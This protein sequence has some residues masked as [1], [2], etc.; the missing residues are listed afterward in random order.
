MKTYQG[1]VLY[2]HEF[3]T[4]IV[5]GDEWSALHVYHYQLKRRMGGTQNWSGC[6][7]KEKNVC[8]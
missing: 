2:L 7:G 8:P 1:V 3:L 6:G 5:D 4:S